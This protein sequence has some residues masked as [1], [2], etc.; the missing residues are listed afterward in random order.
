MQNE[1]FKLIHDQIHH[2]KFQRTYNRLY[3]SIYI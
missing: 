2:E 3:Y 1:M